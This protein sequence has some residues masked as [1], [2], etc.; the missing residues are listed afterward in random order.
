MK[1]SKPVVR[2]SSMGGHRRRS[3]KARILSC[4]VLALFIVAMAGCSGSSETL[5]LATTTSVHDSGLLEELLPDFEEKENATVQVLA[6]GTGQ[7]LAIGERGDADI[8]LVHAKAREEA[9]VADGFGKE[10][11]DLM[12]NSFVILGPASDPAGIGGT[13]SASEAFTRLAAELPDAGSSFVSRGDESGTHSRELSIWEAAGIDPAGD[14]YRSTGQGMGSTLT[15]A[16][17]FQA[18][19]ISDIGTYLSRQ[20]QLDLQVLSGDDPLLFNPY[21]VIPIN[22]DRH[23]DVNYDLATKLVEWLTSFETQE[24]ISEFGVAEFGQSLFTAD[25]EEWRASNP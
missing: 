15:V 9:F 2:L 25:S 20:E 13:G 12:Y 7:A 21:G 1:T 14:W 17:E 4:V 5:I 6:V 3:V 16:N 10:R 24:R 11:F 18:Y 22:P 23:P 19:T 8:I